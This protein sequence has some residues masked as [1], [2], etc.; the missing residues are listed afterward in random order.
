ME[1]RL[2]AVRS[3]DNEGDGIR[4]NGPHDSMF[5]NCVSFQN[6]GA[7][8]RLAGDAAGA[9]I[10]NCHGWGERQ[11]TAFELA[12]PGIGCVNCYADLD[13]GVGVRISHSDCRWVGGL[14]L[15]HNHEP[16]FEE[17]GIQFVDGGQATQP[18]GVVVDTKITNCGTAAVDFGADRGLSSVRAVVSQPGVVDQLGNRVAGTGLSWLGEPHPSTQVEITAGL[19]NSAQNLVVRPAFDVR[20]QAVPPSPDGGAVRI[21]ARTVGGKTQ[22]C[23]MFAGGAV[24]PLATEP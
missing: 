15:G 14:V 4:F 19:G 11:N 20:A 21:F 18:A 10:I 2:T 24:V 9:L 7:G 13:G 16:P 3:H 23:A 8:F 17:I 5:L 12:A 6:R 1:A 22:L